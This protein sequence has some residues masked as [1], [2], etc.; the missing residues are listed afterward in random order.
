MGLDADYGTYQ[1]SVDKALLEAGFK[2]GLNYHSRVH[3]GEG[4]HESAWRRRAAGAMRF[5]LNGGAGQG[6]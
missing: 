1:A 6:S 2:E 3:E 4:H 5:L